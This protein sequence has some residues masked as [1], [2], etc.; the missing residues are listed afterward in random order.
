MVKLVIITVICVVMGKFLLMEIAKVIISV[1]IISTLM[2]LN[3]YV[4]KDMCKLALIVILHV[5]LM[6]M[7]KISIVNAFLIMFMLQEPVFA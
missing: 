5:A 2:E 4:F 7:L 6:H 3:V 1:R